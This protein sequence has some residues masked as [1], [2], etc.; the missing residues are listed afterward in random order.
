MPDQVKYKI[1]D[2]NLPYSKRRM[3]NLAWED[4]KPSDGFPEQK[5]V[6]LLHASQV[7]AL[8]NYGSGPKERIS[9]KGSI[10]RL[11]QG[12]YGYFHIC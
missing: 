1:L 11:Q 8:L 9:F 10:F 12:H 2:R 5:C 3:Y 4:P 6:S 7:T